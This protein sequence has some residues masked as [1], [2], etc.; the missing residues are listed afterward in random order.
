MINIVN[1]KLF[2][3]SLGTNSIARIIWPFN[4]G[5]NTIP[6]QMNTTF[7]AKAIKAGVFFS[8]A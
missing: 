3:F 7:T 4:R 5:S 6:I 1:Y 8:H 2:L